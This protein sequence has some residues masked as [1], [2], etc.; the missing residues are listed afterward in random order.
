MGSEEI[1]NHV[2]Q[3]ED[4]DQ[5]ITKIEIDYSRDVVNIWFRKYQPL[6]NVYIDILLHYILSWIARIYCN[7]DSSYYY[8]GSHSSQGLVTLMVWL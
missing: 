8:A 3:S 1:D 6:N 4:D 5:K 2:F 7:P